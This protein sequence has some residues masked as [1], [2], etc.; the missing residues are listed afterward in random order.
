MMKKKA[1]GKALSL[2]TIQLFFSVGC[3]TRSDG[4]F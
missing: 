1:T 4:I 3:V 2:F